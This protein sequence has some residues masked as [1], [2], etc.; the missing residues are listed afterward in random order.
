MRMPKDLVVKVDALKKQEGVDRSVV[1]NKAVRYWTE[2]GG[3]VTTDH[4]ILVRLT[5]IEKIPRSFRENLR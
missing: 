4:Q 5:C 2:V 3:N 1:I